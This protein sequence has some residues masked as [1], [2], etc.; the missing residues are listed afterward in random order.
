MKF[1]IR[2]AHS[3][4]LTDDKSPHSGSRWWFVCDYPNA[5]EAGAAAIDHLSRSVGCQSAKV[6]QVTIIVKK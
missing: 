3:L 2:A 5:V 4:Y 1:D 6:A